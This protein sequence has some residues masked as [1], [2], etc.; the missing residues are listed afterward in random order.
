M[1]QPGTDKL[2]INVLMRNIRIYYDR[3]LENRFPG[4]VCDRL[5]WAQCNPARFEPSSI[6]KTAAMDDCDFVVCS[7][8]WGEPQNANPDIERLAAEAKRKNKRVVVFV[9]A[10]PAGPLNTAA[11]NLIIFRSSL[12][13]SQQ[14]PFEFVLPA[15]P[16]EDILKYGIPFSPFAWAEIPVVGFCGNVDNNAQIKVPLK[17]FIKTQAYRHLLSNVRLDRALRALGIHLTRHEGRRIRTQAIH[18]LS[19]SPQLRTNFIIRAAYHGGLFHRGIHDPD[20]QVRVSSQK[21]FCA[22][23]LDSHYTLACRGGG[24]FSRRLYETL[25]L[26]RIPVFINTDS[27]MPYEEWVDWKPYCVWVEERDLTRLPRRI[28]EFH[29]SLSAEQFAE[30]QRACRKFWEDW[31]SPRGYFQQFH[32]YLRPLL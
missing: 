22:N 30:K 12:N 32:R 24:N 16:D 1:A 20:P 15:F 6:E 4:Q 7:V 9:L 27:A 28:L 21:D 29:R 23:V 8:F 26:G 5:P 14:R 2:T 18:L 19:R 10:D 31:L 17:R 25:A 3:D 13:K 11:D